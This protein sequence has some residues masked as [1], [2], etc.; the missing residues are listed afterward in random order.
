MGRWLSLPETEGD[1]C[2]IWQHTLPC[3]LARSTHRARARP[4]LGRSCVEASTS[5]AIRC[6]SR[7]EDH[8]DRLAGP[9]DEVA[10][11]ACDLDVGWLTAVRAEFDLDGKVDP[12][13]AIAGRVFPLGP[14]ERGAVEP[15]L[16]L[17]EIVR[18]RT[19]G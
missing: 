19:V 17:R 15:E 8:V 1:C 11:P 10:G 4:D 16:D 9:P 18:R 6:R 3:G 14:P 5:A 13:R 12:P 7:A 2:P